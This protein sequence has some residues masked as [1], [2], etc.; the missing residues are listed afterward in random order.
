MHHYVSFKSQG[1]SDRPW[2]GVFGEP[3]LVLSAEAGVH[4]FTHTGTSYG[5]WGY[6]CPELED[7]SFHGVIEYCFQEW[8]SANNAPEWKD[9]RKGECGGGPWAM[10]N[11]YFWPGTVYA[12]ELP[13]S[14]DTFEVG[15]LGFGHFEAK[16]T[17]TNLISAI[18]L[19]NAECAGWHLSEN[20]ENYALIGVEQG[21]EGWSGVSVMGGYGADLQL[22]TEYTPLPP[23]VS[24]TAASNVQALQATLNGI[25]NPSGSDT[26]YHFEYGEGASGPYEHSTAEVDAGST[27]TN[28]PAAVVISGLQSY[29]SYHYRLVATNIGGTTDGGSQI[30]TTLG[31]T[32]PAVV[33]NASGAQWVYYVGSNGSVWQWSWPAGGK[34]WNS[35]QLGGTVAPGTSPAVATNASGAQWVYYVGSNGSVWQWSWPAGGK[36]WNSYQLGGTVAPGT[37]PAVATN[38]SGAQWV[39]YVGSNGSAWQWSWPAGG[40][41]WNSYQLGGTVGT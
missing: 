8:R 37:S 39:Y 6:V 20:P 12:T 30:F 16:I 2:S 29:T 13:G 27:T 14:A 3:S 36:E 22:H 32:S 21:L 24:T 5:G 19:I 1:T 33:S 18:R 38:A 9:E 25:V 10:V 31:T 17:R 40:K 7:T 15:S 11:T 35:Y 34:E 28:S 23:V 4:T 41:E 26:H